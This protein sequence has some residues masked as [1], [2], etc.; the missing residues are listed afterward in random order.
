MQLI[1]A[2]LIQG[3]DKEQEL[4]HPLSSKI[5]V[6]LFSVV[7]CEDGSIELQDCVK[8]MLQGTVV[9]NTC[10][11]CSSNCSFFFFYFVFLFLHAY[12]ER[13]QMLH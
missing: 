5:V 11:I 3:M 1:E 8:C 7:S 9:S 13:G 4:S 2:A 6:D 12:L 10:N